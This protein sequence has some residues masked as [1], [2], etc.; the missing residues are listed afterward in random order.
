MRLWLQGGRYG[1]LVRDHIIPETTVGV[2]QLT[3]K[4]KDCCRDFRV[5]KSSN[6]KRLNDGI[7]VYIMAGPGSIGYDVKLK[8]FYIILSEFR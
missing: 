7:S 2:V 3:M 6:C 8:S 5:F 4:E 1:D